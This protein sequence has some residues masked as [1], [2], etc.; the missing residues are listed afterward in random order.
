M[1][2][3]TIAGDQALRRVLD[4]QTI[5]VGGFG[6]PGTPFT[7]IEL[8]LRQGTKNLTLVK[9]DANEPGM[10]IS[11]LLEAGQVQTLIASHIGLNS[12]AVAM[13]N[14]REIE[15]LLYP[16]GIL[17]EKIRAGGAGLLGFLTDIGVDTIL[18]ESRQVVNLDGREAILEKAL[19]ADVTLIHAAVADRA[20]NLVFAKSARNFCPLMATAA[21][22][23]IVEAEK[24]VE[25]GTLD[26]D[27][28]HL[29]GAFVD[30]ILALDELTP[31]YGVLPHHAL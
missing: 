11:K 5:M 19:R 8:L 23:V 30:H 9:N 2:D 7:L 3:K 24:V 4:G 31:D 21:A 1:I 28:I 25:T 16:Q 13:M 29:P 15:V 27:R 20:G 22:T 14:R 26:P 6:A 17:A 10:G 18:R 12:T